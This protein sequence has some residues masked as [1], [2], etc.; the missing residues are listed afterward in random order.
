[1]LNVTTSQTLFYAK[2]LFTLNKAQSMAKRLKIESVLEL[3]F[4]IVDSGFS[5]VTSAD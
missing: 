1:M 3:E 5:V 2:F 4:A